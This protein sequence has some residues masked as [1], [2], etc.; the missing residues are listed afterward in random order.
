MRS[1]RTADWLIPA[2]LITLSAIPVIAG[3]IRLAM[4]AG[5]AEVMPENA[6]FFAAPVPVVLHILSTGLFCILGAFQFA[7]GLRRGLPGWHR[8]AGRLLIPCGLMAALSGLWLTGFYPPAE[9]DG[10]LLDGFRVL[11]GSAMVTFLL[12]G[13]AAILRRDVARHRAWMMRSYAIGLGAGT[14]IF[15]HLPWIP[16]FGMPDEL[17]R[18]LLTGAAWVLNLAVAEWIIRSRPLT[19]VRSDRVAPPIRAGRPSA[20]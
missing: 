11:F 10:P 3:A 4:L 19:A 17:S 15:L 13:S 7:P 16:M 18:A 9:G 20:A 14:Q 12:R 8:T 2:A 6:R 1:S 5:G